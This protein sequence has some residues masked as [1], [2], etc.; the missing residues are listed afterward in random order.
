[1]KLKRMGRGNVIRLAEVAKKQA[2]IS[3]KDRAT[4]T[5]KQL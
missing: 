2:L 4:K 3:V 1:M 5:Q